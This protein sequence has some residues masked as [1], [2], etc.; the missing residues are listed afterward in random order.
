M[1]PVEEDNTSQRKL[2][3]RVTHTN[4]HTR[5]SIMMVQVLLKS[6]DVAMSVSC[7]THTQ[8][9]WHGSSH[10]YKGGGTLPVIPMVQVQVAPPLPVRAENCQCT[11]S[12]DR[13]A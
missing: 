3:H 1:R 9:H 4:T 6:N 11:T 2:Q 7:H 13:A 5:R 10:G 8:K 12:L